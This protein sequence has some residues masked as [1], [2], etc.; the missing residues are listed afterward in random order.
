[1][2]I[3]VVKILLSCVKLSFPSCYIKNLKKS[4]SFIIR[5]DHF[6]CTFDLFDK[7]MPKIRRKMKIDKHLCD[8]EIFIFTLSS[9][10]IELSILNAIPDYKR[11]FPGKILVVSCRRRRRVQSSAL[12]KISKWRK[13]IF[14]RSISRASNVSIYLYYLSIYSIF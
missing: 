8:I 11:T 14:K 1:M 13:W 12:G 10:Y 7:E 4:A 6:Q 9:C 5:G 2:S 3:N